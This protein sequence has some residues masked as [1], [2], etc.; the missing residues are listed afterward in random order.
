MKDGRIF[1]EPRSLGHATWAKKI[2]V[3]DFTG[4]GKPDFAVLHWETGGRCEVE[5]TKYLKGYL[6]RPFLNNTPPA[7]GDAVFAAMPK[8]EFI[9]DDYRLYNLYFSDIAVGD[10]DGDGRDDILVVSAHADRID[11]YLSNG[12]G[13]FQPR[14]EVRPKG[15]NDASYIT[16]GNFS[17]SGHLDMA[18]LHVSLVFPG[19]RFDLKLSFLFGN[20]DGTFQDPVTIDE[21]S[22]SNGDADD[23]GGYYKGPSFQVLTLK[24]NVLVGADRRDVVSLNG[25]L[26]WWDGTAVQSDG[27]RAFQEISAPLGTA[28]TTHGLL[29]PDRSVLASSGGRVLRGSQY[30]PADFPVG[31]DADTENLD[32]AWIGYGGGPVTKVFSGAHFLMDD[33]DGDGFVDILV[34][35]DKLDASAGDHPIDDYSPDHLGNRILAIFGDSHARGPL[36]LDM[37]RFDPDRIKLLENAP[38]FGGG[39][40]AWHAALGD[41]DGDGFRDLLTLTNAGILLHQNLGKR[42][43]QSLPPRVLQPTV[44]PPHA[45]GN[46]AWYGDTVRIPFETFDS[47]KVIAA[48]FRP[49]GRPTEG[50]GVLMYHVEA[51]QGLVLIPPE[52]RL[53]PGDY[54]LSVFNGAV[55]SSNAVPI[56]LLLRTLSFES[57]ARR[58]VEKRASHAVVRAKGFFGSPGDFRKCQFSC[59]PQGRPGPETS[60]EVLRFIDA[61]TA[62]LRLPLNLPPGPY[63]LIATNGARGK[64]TTFLDLPAYSPILQRVSW[65]NQDG[66]SAAGRKEPGKPQTGATMRPGAYLEILASHLYAPDTTR[67]E[68]LDSAGTVVKSGAGRTID[69]PIANDNLKGTF[70]VQALPDLPTGTFEVRLVTALGLRS[71][72]SGPIQ[73]AAK[74]EP[75]KPPDDKSTTFYIGVES[76]TE[77]TPCHIDEVKAETYDNDVADPANWGALQKLKNTYVNPGD[78]VFTKV[79]PYIPDLCT[80]RHWMFELT[81]DDGMDYSGEVAAISKERATFDLQTRYKLDRGGVIHKLEKTTTSP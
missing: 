4:D 27:K 69:L 11:V 35:S 7:G 31:F 25:V 19:N 17:G 5:G 56:K 9:N 71:D 13:T 72:L 76:I 74:V 15:V 37:P 38:F 22:F 8:I 51:D 2:V 75:P 41:F 43:L 36:Q 20:G 60:L 23:G 6:V 54:D 62:E 40:R 39:H 33:L 80:K 58:P 64:A 66:G 1:A 45:A 79:D 24:Q 57:V 53:A 55:E 81:D 21:G 65:V 28:R 50:S 46:E 3:G 14:M 52:E 77:A 59:A 70:V 26:R 63:D 29:G 47:R 34:F 16:L 10:V 32:K 12:D 73:T 49:R 61:G 68:L 30:L 44:E 78:F 67:W 48:I 18:V 42:P